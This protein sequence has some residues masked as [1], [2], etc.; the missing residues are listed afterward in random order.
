MAFEPLKQHEIVLM[1]LYIRGMRD[2]EFVVECG[3][4]VEAKAL[5]L[6]AYNVLKLIRRREARGEREGIELALRAAGEV[7]LYVEGG[8]LVARSKANT[9]RVAA[10]AQALGELEPLGDDPVGKVAERVRGE[11]MPEGDA[12]KLRLYGLRD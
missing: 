10:L 5:R 9:P 4:E 6:Q 11:V 12:L 2:G 3:S 7:G 1:N 8:A